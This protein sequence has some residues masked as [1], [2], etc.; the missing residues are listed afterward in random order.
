MSS[1]ALKSLSNT[2]PGARS[3]RGLS[4]AGFTSASHQVT[5]PLRA[6]HAHISGIAAPFVHGN[7]GGIVF[8]QLQRSLEEAAWGLGWIN[9][10]R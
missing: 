7:R 3:A 4:A 10:H 1:E 6:G 8:N 5:E 2:L 9:M